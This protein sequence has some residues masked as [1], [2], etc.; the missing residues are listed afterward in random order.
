MSVI[1]RF[2]VP[3][4]QFP[5]GDVLEV[6]QGIQ[7]RIE[8]MIPTGDAMIPYFWVPND[9]ADAVDGALRQSPLIEEVQIVDHVEA[10]TLF[11][12]DWS[13]EV[14]GLID[15]IEASD[16]VLLEA[17]GLGDDWS[18]R[19]RFPDHQDL[20]AFYRQCTDRGFTPELDEVNNPFGS[21][22]ENGVRITEPQREALM[23]ALDMGYFAV[24][25]EVTLEELAAELGISDTA[26]SQRLR[27]GL[28]ALLSSTLLRET[29]TERAA[30]ETHD[31]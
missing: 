22:E 16:A 26:F 13:S 11:R 2:S 7:I 23:A 6:R 29:S 20:S 5:L 9:D 1:A 4:E 8:S 3:A 24:P 18:F 31:E 25:R 14:N 17:E 10:E 12:V 28:T 19:M 21:S 15:V 27:R 30:D